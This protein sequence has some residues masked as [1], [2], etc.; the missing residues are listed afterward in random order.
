M[1]S[2][3]A[4]GHRSAA[5]GCRP[6]S[7]AAARRGHGIGTASVQARYCVG[8][9][10]VPAREAAAEQTQARG[11]C[12]GVWP[13]IH[14][15]VGVLGEYLSATLHSCRT[16]V[17]VDRAD[18][19]ELDERLRALGVDL[20]ED[21]AEDVGDEPSDVSPCRALTDDAPPLAGEAGPAAATRR[22]VEA[23]VVDASEGAGLE[24]YGLDP[25][26]DLPAPTA[27]PGYYLD[28]AGVLRYAHDSV[29]VPGQQR[30]TLARR[31]RFA[32]D[33]GVVMVP[34]VW[35]RVRDELAWCSRIAA[36]VTHTSVAGGH[37]AAH[38]V[39]AAVWDEMARHY[40]AVTAP[41]LAPDALLGVGEVAEVAQLAPSSVPTFAARGVLPEPTVRLGRV[42]LWSAPVL[43]A[44]LANRRDP[45]RPRRRR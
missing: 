16:G 7:T 1:R 29:Q 24:L 37:I 20:D 31:W 6:P 21:P 35:V 13:G 22:G 5:P 39:P 2:S 10:S 27:P 14:V 25:S 18:L 33:A 34:A 23:L 11:G 19:A 17:L 26:V 15:P 38:P 41:E 36:P 3:H 30:V 4:Q 9:A 45:G 44:W 40:F 8:T 28:G 32:R 43:S 12:R 42:P